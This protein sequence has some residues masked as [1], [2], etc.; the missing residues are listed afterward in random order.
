MCLVVDTC[1]FSHVFDLKD[2]R[3]LEF[4]P[5]FNWLFFGNGGGL[6]YAGE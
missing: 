6:V 1:S 2:K 3:H 4:V 5:V